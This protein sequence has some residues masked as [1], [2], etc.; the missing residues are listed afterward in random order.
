MAR[1]RTL[2]QADLEIVTRNQIAEQSSWRQVSK[3]G[4]TV[5]CCGK[6]FTV[7][8]NV[9]PPRGD[10]RLMIDFLA[11]DRGSSVLD[12]GTGSGVLAIFA[13][14]RGAA[15]ALAVDISQDAVRN[16]TVNVKRHGLQDSIAVRLSDGF[17]AI[18]KT[19]SFATIIANLPGRNEGARDAVEAAQWDSGFKTHRAFFAEAP[20]HLEPGGRVLMTKANYP[21]LNTAVELAE[22]AGFVTKVLARKDPADGDPRTYFVLAFDR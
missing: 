9:F 17:A 22:Q 10:T 20:R 7:H 6:T 19:E 2:D 3:D 13:V 8:P 1:F 16:A 12:M 21:E 5:E 15:S 4:A 11:L 18:A 14:L